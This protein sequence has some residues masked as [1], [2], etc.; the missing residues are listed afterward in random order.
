MLR[1]AAYEGLLQ[2]RQLRP[3]LPVLQAMLA[4][5]GFSSQAAVYGKGPIECLNMHIAEPGKVN[6]ESRARL[7][8]T[9]PV[10]LSRASSSIRSSVSACPLSP[11]ELRPLSRPARCSLHLGCGPRVDGLRCGAVRAAHGAFRG[12]EL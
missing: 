2:A 10:K 3:H 7:T 4:F 12:A 11:S 1:S 6:S 9:C 5:L 8:R